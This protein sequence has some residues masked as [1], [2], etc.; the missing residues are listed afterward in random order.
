MSSV[1]VLRR[2]GGEEA[3]AGGAEGLDHGEDGGAGGLAAGDGDE[4]AEAGRAAD[5]AALGVEVGEA[6]EQPLG[7]LEPGRVVAGGLGQDLLGVP[8]EGALPALDG[9]EVVEGDG[10]ALAAVARA[11]VVGGAHEGVLE[12]G[13]RVLRLAGGEQEAV[14]DGGLDG[15]AVEGGGLVDGAQEGEIVH[16]RQEVLAAVDR[17]GEALEAGTGA[18]VVRAHGRG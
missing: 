14:A 2:V 3:A 10:P 6:A 8:G 9:L 11:G 13:E 12:D 4:V 17:L 1:S 18:E 7:R 5:D 15:A 16:A